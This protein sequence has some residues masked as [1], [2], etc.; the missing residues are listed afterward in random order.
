MIKKIN[1]KLRLFCGDIKH[2]HFV[3]LGEVCIAAWYIKVC[4]L[5][6]GAYP[7][8]WVF[9]SPEI[10]L[11]CIN[12][13]FKSFL[14]K[15]Y[16]EKSKGAGHFKY[17]SRFFK[18]KNPYTDNVNYEYYER[19]C[20][21]FMK[22]INSDERIIYVLHLMNDL[23]GVSSLGWRRGFN[24]KFDLPINQTQKDFQIL[25]DN[26]KERNNNIKFIVIDSYKTKKR[27][28]YYK[29]NGDVF[30]INYHHVG[31]KGLKFANKKDDAVFK[32]ILDLS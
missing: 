28:A 3:S 1:N 23:E 21:R 14:D 32:K 29:E 24:H 13:E 20:K 26:L 18:H 2:T 27:S 6:T 8:D 4:G 9:S 22:L 11:D 31:D 25:I 15:K 16:M 17:H 5:R 30:F 10:V 7:F 19:C 12:D